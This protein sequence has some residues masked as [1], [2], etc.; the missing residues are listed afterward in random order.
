ME[1]KAIMSNQIGIFKG[2]EARIN[3]IILKTL[4]ENGPLSAWEIVKKALPKSSNKNSDHA[5]YNKRLRA[6]EK[7][8]YVIKK[9]KF[10]VLNFKG[11][12]AYLIIQEKTEPFGAFY[13]NRADQIQV[14]VDSEL[15][16]I[17]KSNLVT[18]TTKGT[19][20]RC[21]ENF[22]EGK[23]GLKDF[24]EWLKIKVAAKKLLD[25]GV[26]NLDQ[27]KNSTLFVLLTTQMKD[28]YFDNFLEP[29]KAS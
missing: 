5:T 29:K 1:R 26:I 25:N 27:I 4:Y 24:N 8:S 2:K 18:G 14:Q 7:K 9:D 16:A 17:F 11:L 19:L 6:L 3:E 10:W 21:T 28:N 22:Q 15:D 13:I 23:E 12:L 20:K